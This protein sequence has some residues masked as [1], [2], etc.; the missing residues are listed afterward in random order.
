M[1]RVWSFQSTHWLTAIEAMYHL[2][3]FPITKAGET[4]IWSTFH[5]VYINQSEWTPC[6]R[7]EFLLSV[8]ISRYN[9]ILCVGLEAAK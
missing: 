1:K 6:E 5:C 9:S 4:L 2:V 3:P 8:L 7:I